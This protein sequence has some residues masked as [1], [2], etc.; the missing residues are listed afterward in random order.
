MKG[1]R[2]D[3]GARLREITKP[4][5]IKKTVL[6]PGAGAVGILSYGDRCLA[7][8]VEGDVPSSRYAGSPGHPQPQEQGIQK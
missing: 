3:S 4:Y 5:R 2:P 8:Q 1:S 7:H 6:L